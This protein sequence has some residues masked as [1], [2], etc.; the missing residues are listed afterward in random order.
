M[1]PRQNENSPT[2]LSRAKQN[3]LRAIRESWNIRHVSEMLSPEAIKNFKQKPPNDNFFEEETLALLQR[4]GEL[5][6]DQ[7]TEVK[8][9]LETRWSARNHHREDGP[10][11][12]GAI[13]VG[14]T[15]AI[16][17]QHLR[18]D[19]EEF[20]RDFTSNGEE[21]MVDEETGDSN[22]P[23]NNAEMRVP[24]QSRPT[25]TITSSSTNKRQGEN[26][27][28][29][30]PMKRQNHTQTAKA[31]ATASDSEKDPDTEPRNMWSG[32][33][34]L[35]N[36]GSA[37]DKIE[38]NDTPDND[39]PSSSSDDDEE[40]I[41]IPA[42][43]AVSQIR[44]AWSLSHSIDEPFDFSVLPTHAFDPRMMGQAI[45]FRD[46]RPLL[47]SIHRLAQ[48]TRG[49]S[50]EVRRV[51]RAEFRGVDGFI[52][53][54]AVGLIRDVAR[55]YERESEK[56]GQSRKQ[57]KKNGQA[58]HGNDRAGSK[59]EG[60]DRADGYE[61]NDG[62]T[63]PTSPKR[64]A[65]GARQ[66]LP[67]QLSQGPVSGEG[68]SRPHDAV[69]AATSSTITRSIVSVA[70]EIDPR[71]SIT[72][73]VDVNTL[74]AQGDAVRAHNESL[75]TAITQHSTANPAEVPSAIEH[76]YLL[77]ANELDEAEVSLQLARLDRNLE[78][79]SEMYQGKC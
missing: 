57:K 1:P 64:I 36:D 78:L 48:A 41:K 35:A 46:H 65:Q 28:D 19:I 4:L 63:A 5:T 70:P 42:E 22:A 68:A 26:T 69:T 16:K 37:E 10:H 50:A 39:S 7:K 71:S 21:E 6:K 73:S 34:G 72:Q 45:P 8:T 12:A 18:A 76:D 58:D 3:A 13:T 47:V 31:A 66:V 52:E 54:T 51:L 25:S 43:R 11:N 24:E 30:Q 77:A 29:T 14:K 61:R 17:N 53:T 60:N 59:T 44:I 74:R 23:T 38:E 15:P 55:R 40:D 79:R 32:S 75:L 9:K 27:D 56:R 20:I 2:T 67:Q 49:R 62:Q 33:D